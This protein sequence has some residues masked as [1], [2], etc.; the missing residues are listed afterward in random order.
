MSENKADVVGEWIDTLSNNT[1]SLADT[2]FSKVFHE[3]R[4]AESMYTGVT[5]Q[6]RVRDGQLEVHNT[7]VK[8][9]QGEHLRGTDQWDGMI[10]LPTQRFMDTQTARQELIWQLQKL[11]QCAYTEHSD[12]TEMIV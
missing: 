1:G 4:T 9:R 12:R 5:V 10:H 3:A 2:P 8:T 7:P 6:V 11:Q